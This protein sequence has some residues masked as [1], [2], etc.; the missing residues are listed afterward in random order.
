MA[1]SI[2]DNILDTGSKVAGVYFLSRRAEAEN[3]TMKA[4]AEA[5]ASA[6]QAALNASKATQDTIYKLGKIALAGAGVF[7]AVMVV[8]SGLKMMGRA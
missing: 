7:A 5:D 8:K 6:A 3:A 1:G 4:K 2:L